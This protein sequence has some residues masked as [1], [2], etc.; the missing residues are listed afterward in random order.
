MTTP[1]DSAANA[2]RGAAD[3]SAPDS[4]ERRAAMAQAR[5]PFQGLP[6]RIVTSGV[7]AE[8]DPDRYDTTGDKSGDFNPSG[9]DST[10]Q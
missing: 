8:L 6:A 1:A 2:T 4:P 3:V 7:E 9:D 5:V 10:E